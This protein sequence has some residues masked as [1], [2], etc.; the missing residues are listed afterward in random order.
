MIF[1]LPLR[2]CAL[3]RP[4]LSTVTIFVLVEAQDL[5]ESP[6]AMLTLTILVA[7]F[8]CR[9]MAVV[10][11]LMVALSLLPW[12]LVC[13]C[14]QYTQYPT[15]FSGWNTVAFETVFHTYFGVCFSFGIV[16]VFVAPQT[17]QV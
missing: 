10:F 14:L 16:S 5:T 12:Y 4:F 13:V 15:C 17:V 2:F 8:L 9:V 3:I 1:A 6:F 11:S 7:C